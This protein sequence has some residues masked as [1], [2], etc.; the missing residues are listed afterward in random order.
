[1]ATQNFWWRWRRRMDELYRDAV[2]EGG[3]LVI[4][5]GG[6]VPSQADSQRTGLA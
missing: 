6:D 1:M 4:Y 5:A 3:K 2:A